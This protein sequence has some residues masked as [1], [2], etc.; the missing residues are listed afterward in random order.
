MS[1]KIEINKAACA[2]KVETAWESC[3]PELSNEI[4]KDCQRY[5]KVRSHEL[6][7]SALIHSDLKHGQLVWKTPYARRQYWEI[8]T[9]L[10]GVNPEASW[11]WAELAKRRHLDEWTRRAQQ[12]LKENL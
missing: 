11:Q 6:E 4:L 9:A 3:L 7:T 10:K 2:A 12:L 8:K 5:V 1:V